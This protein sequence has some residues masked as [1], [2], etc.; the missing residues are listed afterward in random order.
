M[1]TALVKVLVQVAVGASQPTPSGQP[2]AGISVVIT[3]PTGAQPAVI[4]TGN[5]TPPWS[6]TTSVAPGA[7][8]ADVSAIDTAGT[9]LLAL[10]QFPFTETG[11]SNTFLPP[12]GVTVTP[13]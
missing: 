1:S 7:S 5:E 2:S 10:P 8:T 6:F 12:T 9:V 3:D 11:T 13:A 4:L